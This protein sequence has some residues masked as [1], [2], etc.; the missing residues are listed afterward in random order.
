MIMVVCLL[1]LAAE[2]GAQPFFEFRFQSDPGDYIG[3]GASYLRTQA[4][5]VVDIIESYDFTGDGSVDY[6]SLRY[7][8]E[9]FDGTFIVFAVG[10][11]QLGRNLAPGTYP[12]AERAP[13]ATLGHPGLDVAM[14]GRGCNTL[15]GNFVIRDVNF[16]PGPVLERLDMDFEQHCEGATPALRGSFRYNRTSALGLAT[17]V[18]AMGSGSLP[19]LASLLVLAAASALKGRTS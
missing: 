5:G 11:N 12:N 1:V 15:A 10:T 9:P 13:F 2:A 14:D 17:P 8:G 18:P 16:A 6:I 7:L 19:V 4:T 3:G